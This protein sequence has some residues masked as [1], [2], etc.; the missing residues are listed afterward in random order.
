MEKCTF[1]IQRIND[2]KGKAKD[3]KSKIKDKDLLTACQQTCPSEAIIFGNENDNEALVN[4]WKNNPRA[5][6]SLEILNTRPAI[7]YLS[8]V[9]NVE[10]SSEHHEEAKD[11]HH[12]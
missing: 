2:A 8:K 7:H 9:R 11:G 12:S 3:T 10:G 5:Y 4:T 6:R 1:C